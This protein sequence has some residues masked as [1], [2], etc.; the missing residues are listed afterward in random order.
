MRRRL[1]RRLVFVVGQ[2]HERVEHCEWVLKTS[3][4]EVSTD[5]FEA[6][7]VDHLG[8]A[9]LDGQVLV[10]A[11]A[12][13]VR[14]S[15]ALRFDSAPLAAACGRGPSPNPSAVV[16]ARRWRHRL[17]PQRCGFDREQA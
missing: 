15:G 14:A 16:G 9:E 6:S 17:A 13:R 11:E 4:G 1:Q 8:L 12:G 10:A 5:A 3:R 2:W 7:Q